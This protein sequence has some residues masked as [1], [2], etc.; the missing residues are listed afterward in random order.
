[1]SKAH[2]D[3]LEKALARKGWRIVAV[4]PGDDLRPPI[5]EVQRG[6]QTKLLIEFSN[7]GPEGNSFSLEESYGCQV[8]GHESASLYFRRI[9]RSRLLWEQELVA[10]VQALNLVAL[11]VNL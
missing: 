8:R 3:A 10:F 5:W 11:T 6:D 1:M 2:L 4:D 9:N 7:L